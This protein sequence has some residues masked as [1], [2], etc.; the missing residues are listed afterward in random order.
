M[1]YVDVPSIRVESCVVPLIQDDKK[2]SAGFIYPK[3]RPPSS[4]EG[5]ILPWSLSN[6]I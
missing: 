4:R 1:C 6:T 3:L 2:G 5:N